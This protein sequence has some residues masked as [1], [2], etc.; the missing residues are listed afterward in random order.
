MCHGYPSSS[1]KGVRDRQDKGTNK[2]ET[3]KLV[4]K[5]KLVA[6]SKA[7]AVTIHVNWVSKDVC[8]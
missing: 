4:A 6:M 5:K 7:D 2:C 3:A 8:K 1:V